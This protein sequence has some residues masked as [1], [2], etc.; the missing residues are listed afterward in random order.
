MNI[1]HVL[2]I[3]LGEG[4]LKNYFNFYY[5]EF[6]HI[7]TWQNNVIKSSNMSIMVDNQP[8]SIQGQSNLTYILP[9]P[10]MLL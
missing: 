10:L 4:F 1:Y 9:H 6:Q 3:P 2:S 7:K 8:L 5:G